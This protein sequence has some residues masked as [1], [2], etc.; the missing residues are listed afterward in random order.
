M[1][2]MLILFILPANYIASWLIFY[3]NIKKKVK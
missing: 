2:I 3:L 1:C